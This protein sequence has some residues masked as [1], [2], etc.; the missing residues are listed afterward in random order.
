MSRQ[1]LGL[2]L[3][4]H[5]IMREDVECG[6]L[7]RIAD[8]MERIAVLLD[9]DARAE[10]RKEKSEQ[11]EWRKKIDRYQEVASWIQSLPVEMPRGIGAYSVAQAFVK[12]HGRE[13]DYRNGELWRKTGFSVVAVFGP[14]RTALVRAWVEAAFPEASQ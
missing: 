10:A 8:A 4:K 12:F 7:L 5:V 6:A 11:I 14:K 9:P 13:A 1:N 3:A 2:D